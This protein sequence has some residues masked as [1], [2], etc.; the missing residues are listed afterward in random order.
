MTPRCTS[1]RIYGFRQCVY[2][3]QKRRVWTGDDHE[4]YLR[5][6]YELF[7]KDQSIGFW[8]S[9]TDRY[10]HHNEWEY[11]GSLIRIPK[12]FLRRNNICEPLFVIIEFRRSGSSGNC[13]IRQELLHLQPSIYQL[14][15]LA[16]LI[17]EVTN[18][19]RELSF[20]IAQFILGCG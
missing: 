10:S 9:Y 19:H 13:P 15:L 2:S 1:I 12:Q 11:C 4:E 18:I 17:N 6:T 8:A 20:D 5:I 14:Q 3:V 16:S 7:R